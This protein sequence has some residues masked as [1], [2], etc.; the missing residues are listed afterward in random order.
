MQPDLAVIESPEQATAV[1]DPVRAMLLDHLRD[2]D[3]AAGAARALKLPRQ[4]LGYHVRALES[5]GL[6]REVGTRKRRNTVER[7]LQST[8]RRYVISPAALGAVGVSADDVR[9][10]FSSEYLVATGARIVRDVAT[11]QRLA[12]GADK[13]LPTLTIETEV[14]FASAHA[15]HEFV[16]ALA[17]AVAELVAEYHDERAP[18]GRR[19]RF[20]VAGHP[21]LPNAPATSEAH[22]VE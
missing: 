12:T 9:D 14:R 8:A 2:P 4:R 3:S 1:L 21:S 5:V 15:S 20:V 17:E 7:L 19:F 22:D 10:R 18:H 11:L 16:S 6:L 13:K